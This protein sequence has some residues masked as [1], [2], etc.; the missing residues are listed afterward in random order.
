[1]SRRLLGLL[2][3]IKGG[4]SN[5]LARRS[6]DFEKLQFRFAISAMYVVCGLKVVTR[7]MRFIGSRSFLISRHSS[8]LI[9]SALLSGIQI[10]LRI[11]PC[12][13]PQNWGQLLYS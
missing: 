8:W 7:G 4:L 5:I 10:G 2:Y 11:A 6:F 12:K 1:M 3:A 9:A 13:H